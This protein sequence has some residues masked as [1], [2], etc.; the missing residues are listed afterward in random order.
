MEDGYQYTGLYH[1]GSRIMVDV[2]IMRDKLE[3]VPIK[4]CKIIIIWLTIRIRWIKIGV[5]TK[6]YRLIDIY[7][8]ILFMYFTDGIQIKVNNF[9]G[10]KKKIPFGIFNKLRVSI[11][12]K[13]SFFQSDIY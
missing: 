4:I 3:Q 1:Y 12:N 9:L 11:E 2:Q 10:F 13:K 5:V 6:L 8:Y 7:I